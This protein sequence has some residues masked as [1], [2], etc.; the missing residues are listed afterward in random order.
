MDGGGSVMVLL[1]RLLVRTLIALMPGA[2]ASTAASGMALPECARPAQ[3][4]TLTRHQERHY[5]EN[6]GPIQHEHVKFLAY[7]MLFPIE[8]DE[9]FIRNSVCNL[10][11]TETLNF[12]WEHSLL[13]NAAL[14]PGECWCRAPR[15]K[16]THTEITSENGGHIQFTNDSSRN[17]VPGEA[18]VPRSRIAASTGFIEDYIDAIVRKAGVYVGERIW[19][20]SQWTGDRVTL[21]ISGKTNAFL[22][23]VS[24]PPRLIENARGYLAE[25]R[26]EQTTVFAIKGLDDLNIKKRDW[27]PEAMLK[28]ASLAISPRTPAFSDTVLSATGQTAEAIEV[29]VALFTNDNARD[30]VAAAP[31]AV[32]SLAN[33]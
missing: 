3:T 22:L 26:S 6:P 1:V 23:A 18:F 7:S 31:I 4:Q 16:R 5:I 32:Y 24:L 13:A 25:R 20:K 2:V 11:P 14:P 17:R 10:H 30:F 8:A 19:F 21:E 29:N 28:E 33:R 12:K 15:I 9:H 27:I